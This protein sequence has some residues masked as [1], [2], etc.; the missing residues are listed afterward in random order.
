MFLKKLQKKILAQLLF[1]M[2]ML[3][4]MP[5]GIVPAL[6][7]QA[8]GGNPAVQRDRGPRVCQGNDGTGDSA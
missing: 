6:R 7:A 3:V 2:V 4:L 8:A 1:I 5:L